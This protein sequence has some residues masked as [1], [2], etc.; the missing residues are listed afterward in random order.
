M[1]H[2]IAE[3]WADYLAS[4]Y[5][6][7]ALYWWKG[8]GGVEMNGH[9]LAGVMRLGENALYTLLQDVAREF[10]VRI[11]AIFDITKDLPSY[12]YRVS[13]ARAKMLLAI[14]M[15]DDEEYRLHM[16]GVDELKRIM[17]GDNP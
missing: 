7:W 6:G 17:R 12:D 14:G 2:I 13:P 5:P 3:W 15:I 8:H 4:G 1:E 10:P 11:E 16:E 9:D